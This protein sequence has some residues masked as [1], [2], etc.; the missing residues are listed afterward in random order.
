M[1]EAEAEQR[2]EEI[3]HHL[4]GVHYCQNYDHPGEFPVESYNDQPE[5]EVSQFHLRATPKRS[6]LDSMS[7]SI[8][9]EEEAQVESSFF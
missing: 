8:P 2:V 5:Q 4:K 6:R 1:N 7:N 9:E 3:E